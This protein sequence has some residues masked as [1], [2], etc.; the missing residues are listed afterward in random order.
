M[1]GKIIRHEF[2]DTGKVCGL[3]LTVIAVVTLIGAL[4]LILPAVFMEDAWSF[5]N[6]TAGTLLILMLTMTMMI[7]VVMLM[8]VT[9]GMMIYQGVH[10]YKTMY[11]DEGYLTQTLPVT[12]HQ[13]LFGKTLVAGIWYLVMMLCI[14]ISVIL[15][16]LSLAF[17]VGAGLPTPS[18]MRDI[19]WQV[20]ELSREIGFETLHMV[21]SV[22]LLLLISPFS[23]MLMIFGGLTIGQLASKHKAMMG[24]L[25]YFGIMIVYMLIG[26]IVQF[27]FNFGGL[28]SGGGPSVA[29]AYDGTTIVALVMGVSM[30]F[31]SHYILTNRLNME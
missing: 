16:I 19:M 30:Y 15:L 23:A 13:L 26:N 17:S 2:K 3:I 28:L 29:F 6:D 12:K 9:Y 4:A 1:L 21:I 5:K 14:G 24:I 31:I 7:Y 8:G 25:A 18:E 11:S 22:V 10:F 27:I 20:G